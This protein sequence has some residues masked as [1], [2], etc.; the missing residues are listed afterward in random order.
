MKKKNDRLI[1]EQAETIKKSILNRFD[2]NKEFVDSIF[3]NIVENYN[4]IISSNYNLNDIYENPVLIFKII[5]SICLNFE[6]DKDRLDEINMNNEYIEN[7]SKRIA[8]QIIYSDLDE[9]SFQ[10]SNA[11]N[12][13]VILSLLSV[14]NIIKYRSG[15]DNKVLKAKY[16]KDFSPIFTLLKE[17]MESLEGTLLLISNKSFSQAMTVYRLYLEQVITATA[18]IKNFNL[19]DKYYEFQNLT[20]KYAK[21]TMDKDVLK[22]L[23]EKNIPPRDVKSFLNYGWIEYLKGFDELP[24]KRYSIKVMAKLCEMDNIYEL[25]SDSTNYVHMNLLFSD[26]NWPKEINKAIETIFAT[27]LGIILNYN[28]FTGFDFIYKNIDLEA[29]IATI[30]SEFERIVSKT[31]Y[32]YDIIRVKSA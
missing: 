10:M 3:N 25:Y 5:L 2:I 19:I 6:F 27:L 32:S 31:D 12:H 13:P 28:K 15:Y 1:L 11:I 24:K 29:E 17:A 7:F 20:I 16:R 23:E 22:V 8:A 18:L 30:F 9:L 4:E 21:N 14:S 26:I